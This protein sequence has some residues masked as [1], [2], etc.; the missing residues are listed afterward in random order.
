M[1]PQAAPLGRSDYSGLEGLMDALDEAYSSWMRDIRLGKA[2]LMVP[3]RLLDHTGRGKGAVFEP[4]RE[5][6]VPAQVPRD[7]RQR[8]GL[9][10]RSWRTSST[11]A[12]RSTRQRAKT[13]SSRSSARPA[14]AGRRWACRVTSPQTATE[15]AARDRK[16]LTTRGKKITYW[17][18]GLADIIYGL[19][20]VEAS[21]FGRGLTPVRPDVDFPDVVI[22]DELAVAQT[23][24]ALRSV[25]TMS[26]Q[27]AVEKVH[28]DWTSDQVTA[29]VARIHAEGPATPL[30]AGAAPLPHPA[31]L[32]EAE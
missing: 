8:T 21:V 25:E 11:S 1:G 24:A 30:G 2:K 15:V 22:P 32:A 3:Q 9:P 14:T 31:D 20:A 18:P 16:S 19:M 29:E 10:R 17:R 5:V 7:R 13:R 4:E 27:V 28:A 6:F 26:I 23:V 12:G